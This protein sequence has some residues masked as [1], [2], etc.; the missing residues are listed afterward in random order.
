VEGRRALEVRKNGVRLSGINF[1]I[2]YE[3]L[4]FPNV[5]DLFVTELLEYCDSFLIGQL[6]EILFVQV[7]SAVFNLKDI[8]QEIDE[9]LFSM[10]FLDHTQSLPSTHAR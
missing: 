5:L 10:F 2:F 4:Y 9:I 3:S 8:V 6:I 7:E 1:P